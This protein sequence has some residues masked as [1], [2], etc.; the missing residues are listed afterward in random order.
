MRSFEIII[1]ASLILSV[2]SALEKSD[3][4]E[5]L[6]ITVKIGK[7]EP[8]S[9][10]VGLFGNVVPKTVEN[11]KQICLGKGGKSLQ[12][13]ER[14][15]IGSHFHRIIPNFMIQGNLLLFYSAACFIW[16]MFHIGSFS[17]GLC[18]IWVMFHMGYVS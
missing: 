3:V 8:L 7:K 1:L 6:T 12:G 13:K 2:F 5:K 9:F 14:T 17:Y 16:V 18:S 4:T 15:Y 10:E 11:F